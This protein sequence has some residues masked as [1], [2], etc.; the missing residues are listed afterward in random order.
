MKRLTACLIAPLFLNACATL[1]GPAELSGQVKPQANLVISAARIYDVDGKT[2]HKDVA[3]V[4]SGRRV[5][6]IQ[7]LPQPGFRGGE[8]KELTV[9]VKA[10]TRTFLGIKRESPRHFDWT[11]VV[12]SEEPLANCT[13]RG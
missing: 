6:R 3:A 5:V 8:V 12:V 11:P 10:C 2:I 4:E 1:Q 13:P 9:E 7:A